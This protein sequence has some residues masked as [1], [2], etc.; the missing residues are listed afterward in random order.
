M[1]TL[2]VYAHLLSACLAIGVLLLQDIA[3]A[4]TQG[5]P[6]SS[7]AIEELFRTA[8]ITF[9]ALA[10]LWVS[11]LVLVLMG[12]L[13]NP[14]KYLLNQKLWAKFSVVFIL[15][16]NGFFLHYYAFPKVIAPCGVVGLKTSEQF[17][18]LLSGSISSVSWLFACYLGIARSW[19]NTVNYSFV[20]YIY[21]FLIVVTFIVGSEL[22]NGAKKLKLPS[23]LNLR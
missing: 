22:L 6:L 5:K 3:L 16:I 13:D 1:K 15:T 14:E 8:K 10:L 4:K 12:Y 23:I 19:N 11:G 18:V 7:F 21:L 17:L 9:F 20:M 2:I